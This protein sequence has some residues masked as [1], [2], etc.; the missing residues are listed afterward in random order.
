MSRKA[1]FID[2]T[3]REIKRLEHGG[4]SRADAIKEALQGNDIAETIIE[5]ERDNG[6]C[7]L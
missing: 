3:I 1:K 2:E 5:A 7:G 6:R 4:M